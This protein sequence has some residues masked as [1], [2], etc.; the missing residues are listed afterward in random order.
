[1]INSFFVIH[2]RTI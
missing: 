2:L 1:M